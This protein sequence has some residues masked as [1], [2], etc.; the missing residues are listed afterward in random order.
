MF[1]LPLQAVRRH[2]SDRL[3]TT[4]DSAET[5]YVS[6]ARAANL[7]A[8]SLLRLDG[9]SRG[10][11]IHCRQGALWVTQPGDAEDHVVR[12]GEAF[13][14]TRPG[15]LVIQVLEPAAFQIV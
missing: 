1:C 6:S 4:T 13:T 12:V 9:D 10:R 3:S 14:V 8:G 2:A 7:P 5:S 11:L 15:R